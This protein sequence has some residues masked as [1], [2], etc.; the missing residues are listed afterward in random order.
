MK[1]WNALVL[2]A[3]LAA[4]CT[5]C[6][7]NGETEPQATPPAP[8]RD[9]ADYQAPESGRVTPDT[10]EN[11]PDPAAGSGA[12]GSSAGVGAS[13]STQTPAPTP[14]QTPAVQEEPVRNPPQELQQGAGAQPGSP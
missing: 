3:L 5:G 2:A 13:P 8:T 14:G 10:P 9:A 1:A 6:G 7:E 12:A 4:P 11:P